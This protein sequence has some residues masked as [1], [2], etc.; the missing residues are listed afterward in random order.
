M[1]AAAAALGACGVLAPAP[2]TAAKAETASVAPAW[3]APMP[4]DGQQ[5]RLLDWWGQFEDRLL[6]DLIEAAQ[7]VSPSLASARSR[8]EQARAARTASSAG[9][10]PQIDAVGAASRGRA[11]AEGTLA[12]VATAA[13]QASWELDLFG[14]VR[15]GAD[16]GQARLDGAQAAWHSARVSVAAET[17][18]AYLALRACEAQLAEAEIDV[19]SRAESARIT[20]RSAQAGLSAPAAVAQARASAAQS[21]AQATFQRSQ[22]EGLVKA[23]VALTALPEPDLRSRLASTQGQLPKPAPIAFDALPARVLA[24]RPDLAEAAAAV[25]AAAADQRLAE[26]R[27]WPRVSLAGTVGLMGLRADGMARDGSTW[28]LGPLQVTFPLFDGGVRRANAQAARAAYDEQVLLYQARLRTAVR[29]VEEAM[30]LLRSTSDRQADVR[31][32]ADGYEASFQAAQ[33]RYQGGIASLFEL[34]DARRAAVAARVAV[35][36]LQRERTGAWIALYRAL[37]GGWQASA[38]AAAPTATR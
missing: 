35:I 27:R 19:Q 21:R 28:T 4:H 17:A 31:Q 38:E 7:R 2:E 3:L 37:G 10:L 29:E 13:V 26:A 23:L 8:V 15:A 36:D 5:T 11:E 25:T 18:S 24:Q 6:V 30:V 22:C 32:A 16:A 20:E 12:S 9:A 1:L 14:A 33:S 34:E